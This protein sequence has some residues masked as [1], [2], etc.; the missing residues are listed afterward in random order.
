MTSRALST[1]R[2]SLGD[3]SWQ[4][5]KASGITPALSFSVL[6]WKWGLRLIL[7]PIVTG[8]LKNVFE[9]Y[10]NWFGKFSKFSN[11]NNLFGKFS[12]KW[13]CLSLRNNFYV[14]Y[15]IYVIKCGYQKWIW[16]IRKP[17]TAISWRIHHP[18]FCDLSPAEKKNKRYDARW[19]QVIFGVVKV[20]QITASDASGIVRT[21]D[22]SRLC[23]F[24]PTKNPNDLP[25]FTWYFRDEL[26]VP[27]MKNLFCRPISSGRWCIL[28]EGAYLERWTWWWTTRRV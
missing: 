5:K 17:A 9:M 13:K 22:D 6:W 10:S 19:T 2:L 1:K 15:L 7:D 18:I 20:S 25:R 4:K 27:G 3:I 11:S 21:T 16:G 23:F 24:R 26:R 28:G 12:K 14:L 8:L